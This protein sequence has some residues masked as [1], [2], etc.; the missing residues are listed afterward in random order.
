[1]RYI[2]EIVPEQTPKVAMG[3]VG[4]TLTDTIHKHTHV[5]IGEDDMDDNTEYIVR[6]LTPTECSRLQGFPDGHCDLP[7]KADMTDEEFTE[8][9][10]IRRVKAQMEGKQYRPAKNKDAM[11]KWYNKMIN[12]MSNKYRALGNSIAIPQWYWLFWKMKPYLPEHPTL[13][14]LFDGIGGFPCAF[15]ELYGKGSAVWASEV[16]PFPIAVTKERFPDNG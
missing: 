7:E 15:E 16:E 5:V 2:G 1:M 12:A 10:E 9:Q 14:S 13:G 11:L 6:R 4:F 8:W 3:G